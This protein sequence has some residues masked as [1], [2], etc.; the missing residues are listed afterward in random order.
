MEVVGQ[1]LRGADHF[2]YRRARGC[3]EAAQ[4]G[5]SARQ[6][7]GAA[8]VMRADHKLCRD[9]RELLPE[10]VQTLGRNRGQCFQ[11]K[12]DQGRAALCKPEQQ[13]QLLFR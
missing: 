1:A 13:P 2:T 6:V 4:P 8:E 10:P 11:L 9:G 5:Q 3:P 12:V 7:A